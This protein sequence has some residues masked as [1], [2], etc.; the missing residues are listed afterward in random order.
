MGQNEGDARS[1]DYRSYVP[2]LDP[3]PMT[4]SAAVLLAMS[5]TI[6]KMNFLVTGSA[7]SR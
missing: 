4:H 5:D 2:V 6:T 7:Y 1:L 3:R